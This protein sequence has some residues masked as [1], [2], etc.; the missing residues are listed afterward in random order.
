[1]IYRKASA[2]QEGIKRTIFSYTP[3]GVTSEIVA[4]SCPKAKTVG[5]S[6]SIL[7]TVTFLTGSGFTRA[8]QQQQQHE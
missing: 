5:G 6:Y 3:F 2:E 8:K 7:S 4:L 1:M